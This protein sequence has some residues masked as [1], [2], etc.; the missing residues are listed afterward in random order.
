MK[1]E[2]ASQEFPEKMFFE[3]SALLIVGAFVVAFA[4]MGW[5]RPPDSMTS[6]P[7]SVWAL[8]NFTTA[9][10]ENADGLQGV[11]LGGGVLT[12][13]TTRTLSAAFDRL[14]YDWT[15]VQKSERAVPRVFLASMPHDLSQIR[16]VKIRKAIFF[17]TMLP[18]ILQANEEI[19]ADRRRLWQM[20]YEISLG[21]TPIAKDR[22]WLAVMAD[23]YRV[24]RGDIAKLLKRVDV[25][26]PSMA[27]AQ[28]AEESGWGTSRFAREGNAIFGQWTFSEIGDLVPHKRDAGKSHKVRAFRSLLDSVR[29]Y[30]LNIN[31]HRAYREF[32]RLRA[33]MRG[34]GAPLEGDVLIGKL[35][36][37]S[38]RGK[39]YVEVI[40]GIIRFNKLQH[41]DGAKLG[42]FGTKA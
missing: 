41:F 29:A 4:A 40:R 33:E 27:L 15:A 42:A 7:K 37:Y 30:T 18:L 20:H 25:I 26:P 24:K 3:R 13:T 34:A 19:M 16:Q 2:L 32:R 22:L 10:S 31:G 36:R 6:S 12:H 28:A 39:K 1:M 5:L 8:L 17:K 9:S 23:R 14:G 38:E 35:Q 11:V 21:Q